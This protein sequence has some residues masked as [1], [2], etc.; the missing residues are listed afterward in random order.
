MFREW[1][2]DPSLLIL[3]TETTGLSAKAEV[4]EI[5]ILDMAGNTIFHSLVKPQG[6]ISTRASEV[7]GLY[8]RHLKDAP[9]WP[10]VYQE[11]CSVLKGRQVLVYNARFDARLIHQTCSQYGLAVPACTFHCVM[12]AYSAYSQEWNQQNGNYR[13]H[14]LK[15]AAAWEG[16]RSV[17]HH[18]ALGDAEMTRQ[19]VQAIG[20]K[21]SS[22]LTA[23]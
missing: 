4:L 23:V 21:L 12:L 14:K 17:Q 7:H 1:A 13:W 6:S 2:N 20:G 3:D 18:R 22:A 15:D 11:L 16:I 5:G 8:K 9:A 10:E 19:L